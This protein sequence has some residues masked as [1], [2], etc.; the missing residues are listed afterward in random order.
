[1]R[2][3]N[4]AA[5]FTTAPFPLVIDVNHDRVLDLHT[6]EENPHRTQFSILLSPAPRTD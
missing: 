2:W 3:G 4:A 5:V 1:M 6:R